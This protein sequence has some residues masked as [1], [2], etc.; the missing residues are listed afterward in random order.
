VQ[1]T[2]RLT[3]SS[4]KVAKNKKTQEEWIFNIQIICI[5]GLKLLKS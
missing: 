1:Y 3:F 5:C 4:K 2:S